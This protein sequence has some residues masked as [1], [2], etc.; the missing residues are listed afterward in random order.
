MA[1]AAPNHHE[2]TARAVKVSKLVDV[3]DRT[4]AAVLD[5]PRHVMA[6]SIL[7][8]LDEW[9]APCWAYLCAQ[10]GTNAPSETTISLI[11]AVYQARARGPQ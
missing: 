3:I 2:I 4:F 7:L 6:R 8:C 5:T 1:N 9:T 11:R 10:A